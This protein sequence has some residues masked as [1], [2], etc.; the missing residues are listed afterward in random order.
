MLLGI[1]WVP[2]GRVVSGCGHPWGPS[3]RDDLE[4][5]SCREEQPLLPVGCQVQ[6][7]VSAPCLQLQPGKEEKG[8]CGSVRAA[9][10]CCH[11]SFLGVLGEGSSS[12]FSIQTPRRTITSLTVLLPWV[13]KGQGSP[14]GAEQELLTQLRGLLFPCCISST[15]CWGR[16]SPLT[17][18]HPHLC[19]ASSC[20]QSILPLLCRRNT[21]IRALSYLEVP[22]GFPPHPLAPLCPALLLLRDD[23]QGAGEVAGGFPGLCTAL[24]QR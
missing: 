15:E 10:G 3:G 8:V 4:V 19:P 23:R 18:Q 14:Q 7:E 2:L 13:P 21:Q 11:L 12:R 17:L 6:C 20:P 9:P 16:W 5:W 1:P 22:Y 24:Q